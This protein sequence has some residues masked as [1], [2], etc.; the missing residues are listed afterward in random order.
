MQ[1]VFPGKINSRKPYLPEGSGDRVAVGDVQHGK[2]LSQ[3]RIARIAENAKYCQNLAQIA[4]ALESKS[5]PRLLAAKHST[6]AFFGNFGSSVI[7]FIG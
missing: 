5:D 1:R 3:E 7:L 2:R 4:L 6:S